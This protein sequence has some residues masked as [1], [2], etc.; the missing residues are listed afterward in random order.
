[1]DIESQLNFIMKYKPPTKSKLEIFEKILEGV[2]EMSLE[3]DITDEFKIEYIN[4]LNHHNKSKVL[5]ELQTG[6]YP[7][8]E[9]L[10]ICEQK[11]SMLAVAYLK[12]RLGFYD[13]A[14]DIYKE[15]LKKVLKALTRGGKFKKEEKAK[16]LYE[17]FDK[18]SQ[19]ALT[20]CIESE[21]S[22]KVNLS[23]LNFKTGPFAYIT[24]F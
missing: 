20:L 10:H 5:Y 8:S 4:L 3:N 2:K 24:L 22:N 11:K 6:K 7:L 16:P 1:M 18:E 9:C 12:E 15:R 13:Q 23:N 14:L 17:R 21:G 19:M